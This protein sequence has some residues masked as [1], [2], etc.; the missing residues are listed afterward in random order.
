MQI[1]KDLNLPNNLFLTVIEINIFNLPFRFIMLHKM[2]AY[3]KDHLMKL[4]KKLQCW[5]LYLPM[6]DMVYSLSLDI[7]EIS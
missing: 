5:S 6:W 4:L 2:E 3:I 7:F 1:Y